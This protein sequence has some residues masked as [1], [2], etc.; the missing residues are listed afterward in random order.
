M[1]LRGRQQREE[2]RAKDVSFAGKN[3]RAHNSVAKAA[4]SVKIYLGE[5]VGFD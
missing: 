1:Y 2:G 4:C 3:F 5:R